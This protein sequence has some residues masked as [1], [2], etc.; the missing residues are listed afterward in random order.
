[1]WRGLTLLA[2][3]QVGCP[4]PVPPVPGQPATKPM[5]DAGL[6]GPDEPAVDPDT[7]SPVGPTT[8]E[9]GGTTSPR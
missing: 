5:P 2:L 7:G 6:P 9:P 8:I 4:S 3:L 1:M